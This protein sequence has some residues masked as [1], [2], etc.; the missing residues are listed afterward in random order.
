[1]SIRLQT[2]IDAA[3]QLSP[4]E[5]VD[6]I[7][8]ISH[9]LRHVYAEEEAAAFWASKSLD[10]QLQLQKAPVVA[11]L[12]EWRADFWPEEESVDELNAYLYQQRAEDRLS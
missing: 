10:E 12:A 1:M 8:A 9:S 11:D 2:L 3:Q 7:D 6:L 4:R 5:R